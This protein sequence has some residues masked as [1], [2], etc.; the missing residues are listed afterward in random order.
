MTLCFLH[1]T[2]YLQDVA[3]HQ[4]RHLRALLIEDTINFGQKYHVSRIKGNKYNIPYARQWYLNSIEDVKRIPL[5][6]S[7]QNT[8]VE[9]FCNSFLRT[10]LPNSTIQF[11]DTFSL[12]VDRLRVLRE[13]V[14]DLMYEN[15]CCD[16]LVRLLEHL[17]CN[18]ENA[19]SEAKRRLRNDLQTI[20]G[21][22]S[23]PRFLAMPIGNISVEL[24]RHALRL[25]GSNAETDA[26]LVEL[27]ESWLQRAHSDPENQQH[28]AE[29]L[30]RELRRGVTS[31][32]EKYLSSSPWDIFNALVAPAASSAQPKPI[33]GVTPSHP[34][35]PS[36][37]TDIVNR[38]THIAVLHWRIWE[39]IVYNNDDFEPPSPS[40]PAVL[41]NPT[42]RSQSP[43]TTIQSNIPIVP[44][45]QTAV[46][47]LSA[48]PQQT[49]I[50]ASQGVV[51]S[52]PL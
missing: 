27:T 13:E 52:S 41:A 16:I 24:V 4:I 19:T 12:D 17:K 21:D 14:R 42:S 35:R 46:A 37:R 50:D 25:S 48:N 47:S 49:D 10:L 29:D 45:P 30:F 40:H 3:N 9:V 15:I 1:M 28:H 23:S 51:K 44:G 38:I 33:P 39:N 18:P 31:S 7:W 36:R 6:L 43:A 20:I 8:D 11:P 26:E 2:D 22:G 32:V 34:M 5:S